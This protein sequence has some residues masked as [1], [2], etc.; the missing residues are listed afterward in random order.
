M[1]LGDDGGDC[2]RCGNTT[3]Q[4]GYPNGD[5]GAVIGVHCDRCD[6][7]IALTGDAM[8]STESRE[9]EFSE[10]E[11]TVHKFGPDPNP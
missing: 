10:F 7:T 2:P 4:I 9:A 8:T 1:G 5:T 11:R 6:F 3:V